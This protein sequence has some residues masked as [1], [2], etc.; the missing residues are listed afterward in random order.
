MADDERDN[1]DAEDAEPFVPFDEARQRPKTIDAG[2]A[3]VGGVADHFTDSSENVV[4]EDD[5]A[6]KEDGLPGDNTAIFQRGTTII[7]PS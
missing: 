2:A 7:P 5:F 1:R 6:G 3:D 4:D